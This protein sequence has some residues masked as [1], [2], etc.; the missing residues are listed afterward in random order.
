MHLRSQKRWSYF[1]R[2]FP[3]IYYSVYDYYQKS[4]LCI[5]QWALDIDTYLFPKPIGN[6]MGVSM[7]WAFSV[8]N[9]TPYNVRI[10]KLSGRLCGLIRATRRFMLHSPLY[11]LNPMWTPCVSSGISFDF[12]LERTSFPGKRPVCPVRQPFSL[13]KNWSNSLI[14]A[15]D[16]LSA[17]TSR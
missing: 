6:S 12:N 11:G 1:M 2:I 4:R 3:V 17:S 16:Q 9:Q 14:A 15:S 7:V 5:A 13:S 10:G 8:F